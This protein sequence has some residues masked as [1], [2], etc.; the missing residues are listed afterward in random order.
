MGGNIW[1][2]KE[3]E[4]KS[5]AFLTFCGTLLHGGIHMKKLYKNAA[6]LSFILTI[7]L[8]GLSILALH[9]ACKIKKHLR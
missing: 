7:G 5:F 8:G 2:R 3:H 1:G 6:I 4:K 9:R